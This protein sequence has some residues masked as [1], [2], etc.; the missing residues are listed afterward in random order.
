[1]GSMWAE[2][3]MGGQR[4]QKLYSYSFWFRWKYKLATKRGDSEN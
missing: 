3:E 1:M 2:M 4:E